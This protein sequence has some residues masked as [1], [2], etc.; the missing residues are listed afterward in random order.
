MSDLIISAS[1]QFK[2]GPATVNNAAGK[3][4]EVDEV[5]CVSNNDA[6]LKIEDNGDGTWTA[7][8]V[9]VGTAQITISGT[10]DL[11]DGSEPMTW[12]L[13]VQIAA[14]KPVGLDV[15][16]GPP[17]DQKKEG[18]EEKKGQQQPKKD[19]PKKEEQP[20]P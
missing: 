15:P 20:K 14:A 8:G 6:A 19:Q 4:V 9:A 3:P 13:D 11:G 17:E 10:V 5:T 12:T 2:L 16:V 18:E 1:K 7:K